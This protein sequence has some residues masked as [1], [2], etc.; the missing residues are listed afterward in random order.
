MLWLCLA[1]YV[2]RSIDLPI[3]VLTFYCAFLE[4]LAGVWMGPRCKG[5]CEG[6]G[7]GFPEPLGPDG[8]KREQTGVTSVTCSADCQWHPGWHPIGVYAYCMTPH[9]LHCC[10]YG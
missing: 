3:D 1:P 5:R 2:N 6:V 7:G 4:S 9:V 10:S 8:V